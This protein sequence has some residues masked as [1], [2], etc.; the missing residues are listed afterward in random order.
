[1]MAKVKAKYFHRVACKALYEVKGEDVH[2]GRTVMSYESFII[3][4]FTMSN[5]CKKSLIIH[6][7]VRKKS[8]PLFFN[9]LISLTGNP[10]GKLLSSFE[11][12]FRMN[13]I[14][15]FYDVLFFVSWNSGRKEKM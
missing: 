12:S 5:V 4:P 1:M 15:V 2:L 9:L 8:V 11:L 10:M 13:P 14:Q 3:M 6:Y 7:G